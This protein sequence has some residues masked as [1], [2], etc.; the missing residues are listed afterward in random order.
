MEAKKTFSDVQNEYKIADMFWT[1][2]EEKNFSKLES[3]WYFSFLLY[4]LSF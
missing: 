3:S 4:F 2:N 1:K